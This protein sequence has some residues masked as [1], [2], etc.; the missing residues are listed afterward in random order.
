MSKLEQYF[1]S[2]E[3][4]DALIKQLKELSLHA[5]TAILHLVD[6]K[7]KEAYAEIFIAEALSRSLRFLFDAMI[8]KESEIAK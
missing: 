7:Y 8:S 6:G 1:Q 4:K 2:K 5:N 3:L